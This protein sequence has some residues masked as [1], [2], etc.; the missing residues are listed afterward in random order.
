ML[1]LNVCAGIMILSHA[2]TIE[3][4]AL[5]PTGKTKNFQRRKSLTSIVVI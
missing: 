1:F 2:S 3:Q 5:K 4:M